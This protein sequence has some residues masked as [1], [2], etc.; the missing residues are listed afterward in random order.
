MSSKAKTNEGLFFLHFKKSVSC[1]CWRW[2]TGLILSVFA[3]LSFFY[4]YYSQKWLLQF[5]A[6]CP[7]SRQRGTSVKT[8]SMTGKSI[9]ILKNT[10]SF[11]VMSHWLKKFRWPLL[12]QKEALD[13]KH[14]LRK[15]SREKTQEWRFSYPTTYVNNINHIGNDREAHNY[16]Q[17]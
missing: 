7:H 2:F 16:L 17:L 9:N 10:S 4:S 3:S 13:W 12:T 14:F 15:W 11:N 8:A 5:L 6:F 1:F